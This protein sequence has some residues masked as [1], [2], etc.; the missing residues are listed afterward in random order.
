MERTGNKLVLNLTGADAMRHVEPNDFIS[1]LRS[2]QGGFEHSL[3]SGKVSAAYTVLEPAAEAVPEFFRYVFKSSLYVQALQTTTDQLRDGQSI[4]YAQVSLLP[5]PVPT[6]ST[7]RA[8]AAFL[9][10]ETAEIDA[11]IADQ[12]EL[13]ALLTERRAATITRAV[14]KGLDRL[15]PMKDSGVAWLGEVPEHWNLPRVAHVARCSSGS[16]IDLQS[17]EAARTVD[18]PHPVYGGNGI[19]GYFSRWNI[20]EG[21][22]VVGRVGALCGNVHS[23]SERAWVSDNALRLRVSPQKVDRDFLSHVLTARDLNQLADKTAQPLITGSLVL[24]QRIPAPPMA[25]QA[26]IASHLDHETAKIDATI[27]DAREAIALSKERRAA[28]ISAAVTGKI[29]VRGLA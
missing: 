9:D 5:L 19:V 24:R 7:Q 6:N 8:I 26:A 2:F 3:H 16:S 17:V 22:I 25:E 13:I 12:E 14:T 18:A 1:H 15:A 27:T 23:T 11:F 21:Q 4:R 29:D 20:S 10:R 28:L